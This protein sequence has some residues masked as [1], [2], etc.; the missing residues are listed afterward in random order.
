MQQSQNRKCV[1][2]RTFSSAREF[3][4][5]GLK[6]KAREESRLDSIVQWSFV[7]L[8]MEMKF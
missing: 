4:K 7:L 2:V 5:K 3:V 6:A 8:I 1:H